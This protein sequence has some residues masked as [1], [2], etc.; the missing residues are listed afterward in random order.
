MSNEIIIHYV[1]DEA[2]GFNQ[3]VS[4]LKTQLP[5]NINAVSE[6]TELFAM[7]SDCKFKSD[8]IVIDVERLFKLNG[9]DA[10]GIIDTLSTI[11]SCTVYREENV[12]KPLHR[13][14]KI[15]AAVSITTNPKLIKELLGTKISGFYPRGLEFNTTEKVLAI[16]ELLSGAFHVPVKIKEIISSKHKSLD[17][18]EIVL[19][20]RQEQVA[21]LIQDRGASNKVIAKMLNITESTV[22][23]HVTQI[24][25]KYGVRNRTQLAVFQKPHTL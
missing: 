18:D 8:L 16:T 19:T 3:I 17:K 1:S 4:Q 5:L 6:I 13:N 7:L 25:K 2:P 9:A 14:T 12:S 22:K 10:F 23:L 11:I 20:P 21:A 15:V 24:F